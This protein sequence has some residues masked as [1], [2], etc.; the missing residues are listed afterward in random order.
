MKQNTENIKSEN[1]QNVPS[2]PAQVA[3]NESTLGENS[4]PLP[5]SGAA[6]CSASATR[7]GL[8]QT[9]RM[10]IG[11]KVMLSSYRS[12]NNGESYKEEHTLIPISSIKELF[13]NPESVVDI[14]WQH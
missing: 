2:S 13:A 10:G 3:G 4:P 14:Q 6:H 12:Y 9:L 1:G 11:D 7:S 8:K 5:A